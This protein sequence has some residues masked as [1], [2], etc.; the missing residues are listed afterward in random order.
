M[1]KGKTTMKKVIIQILKA[2]A[3]FAVYFVTL[4][5]VNVVIQF[6]V[7]FFAAREYSASGMSYEEAVPLVQEK[8]MSFTGIQLMVAAVLILLIFTIVE[9][10]KKSNIVKETDMK[11][12]SAK[13][14]GIT[15]AGALG[16]MV[17]LN[18]MLSILPIPEEL[19]GNLSDGM[20]VLSAY[21]LWQAIIANSLLIPILE[22]VV[23]RGYLFNRLNK[24][25]PSVVVALITSAVFG[26]CHGG[27]VWACWAFVVGMVICV[28]R[29]KTGS[30]IPGIIFHVIMNAF[31]VL[32]SYTTILENISDTAGIV[33]TVIG[34]LLLAGY[35]VLMLLDKGGSSKKSRAEVTIS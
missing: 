32:T 19:M 22:E 33:A 30:I 10:V 15:I 4:N 18:A 29:I 27:I 3:Y 21:P 35:I 28:A 20:N 25:M 5:T 23:F 26:L 24:V 16:G 11:K 13:Q 12:V 7:G 34:G 6:L 2:L 31:S 14:I 1:K 9:A 17:F 8:A